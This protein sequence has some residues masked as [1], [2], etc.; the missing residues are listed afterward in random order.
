MLA[1]ASPFGWIA[2]LLSERSRLF[3]FFFIVVLAFVGGLLVLWTSRYKRRL[4]A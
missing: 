3:P 1:V 4:G 2:G